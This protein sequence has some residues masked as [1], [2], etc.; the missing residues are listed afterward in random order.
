MIS[1]SIEA[2]EFFLLIV[3]RM[4][5]FI[6]TSPIFN[7][8]TIPTRVKA[9]ISVLLAIITYP[10]LDY[11]E[12][13]YTGIFGFSFL[14]I[15][16]VVAGLIIG[17]SINLC[18][19]ILGF[20]GHLVDTEIGFAMVQTMNPTAEFQTTITGNLYTYIVLLVI[21]VTDSHLYLIDAIIDTYSIIPA[22]DVSIPVNM[23]V[24]ILK[25]LANYFLIGFRIFLPMFMCLLV[26][27]AILGILTKVSPEMNM[28]AIG[29][30]IKIFVGI[31]VLM[32]TASVIPGLANFLFDEMKEI[33]REVVFMMK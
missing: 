8:R 21:I 29:F 30:Q 11:N 17:F 15:K 18:I 31:I 10:L 23:Y 16:E 24:L 19:M 13:T 27:N 12:L 5:A 22:G 20:A 4:S 26:T 33:M 9:G 2:L 6:F 32:M 25:F 14:V 28:F 7:Q 1:F 3:A